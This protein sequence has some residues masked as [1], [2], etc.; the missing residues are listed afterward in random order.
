MF[1]PS[2]LSDTIFINQ[3]LQVKQV[4]TLFGLD[5]ASSVQQNIW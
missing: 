2:L 3:S 4:V 1:T 5:S